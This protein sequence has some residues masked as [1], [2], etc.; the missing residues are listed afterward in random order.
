MLAFRI[1]FL[2]IT[3]HIDQWNIHTLYLYVFLVVTLHIDQWNIHIL[4][5]YVETKE[6]KGKYCCMSFEKNVSVT[7][8]LGAGEYLKLIHFQNDIIREKNNIRRSYALRYL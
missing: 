5:L 7:Y 6:I 2:V 4:Y 8:D 1:V 3:L